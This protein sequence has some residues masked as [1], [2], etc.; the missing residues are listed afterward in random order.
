MISLYESILKSVNAGKRAMIEK[1]CQEH[2]PFA[3]NWEI[4]KDDEIACTKWGND[5]ILPFDT[6]TELPDYIQFADNTSLRV[7]VG[8]KNNPMVKKIDSLR[9]LPKMCRKLIIESY[10]LKELPAFE[11]KTTY[12]ALHTANLNKTGKITIE[13]FGEGG[14]DD[15]VIRIKDMPYEEGK[16]FADLLPNLHI[17]GARQFDAM[18]CAYL[19]DTFSKLM[20]R[21]AEMNKYVGRYEFPISDDALPLIEKYFG[22]NF[23]M[24]HLEEIVYTQNSE[25][26][27]K[28]GKWY[29][30]K[31]RR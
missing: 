21:K 24:S 8:N 20:N 29:R 16:G 18:N 25:L 9:G 5:L 30:C 12:F 1:W 4:T 23:D 26:I 7:T 13:M 14:S 3:G 19:G 2:N 17:K 31:N 28:N 11:I 15:R 27:K 10:N 22:K 6:Y